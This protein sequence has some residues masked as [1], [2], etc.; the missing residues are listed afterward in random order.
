MLRKPH[1]RPRTSVPEDAHGTAATQPLPSRE[2][3]PEG[4]RRR[5]CRRGVTCRKLGRTQGTRADTM[6]GDGALHLC[7]FPV[8]AHSPVRSRECVGQTRA[9]ALLGH[10]PRPSV[11]PPP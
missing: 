7:G 2:K 3:G 9:S 11:P 4:A 6:G 10:L 8:P 1:Q 5:S